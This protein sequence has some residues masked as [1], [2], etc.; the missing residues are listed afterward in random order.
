MDVYTIA[1]IVLAVV[2]VGA[3]SYFLL[4]PEKTT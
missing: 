1:L 3:L 2:V 4:R